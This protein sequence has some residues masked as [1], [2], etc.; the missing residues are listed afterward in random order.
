[1][2]WLKALARADD[3]EG[4]GTGERGRA[5]P[6]LRAA[7]GLACAVVACAG[8]A[9]VAAVAA[10]TDAAFVAATSTSGT[11][12]A[13]ALTATTVQVTRDCTTVPPVVVG[14]ATSVSDRSSPMTLTLPPHQV[15][16]LL[17]VVATSSTASA[18]TLP[19]GWTTH[20]A[21]A[22]V[23]LVGV[24]HTVASRVATGADTTVTVSLAGALTQGGAVAVAVRGATASPT[25]ASTAVL[26]L[27]AVTAPHVPAPAGS[28]VLTAM[29]ADS[30]TA[31]TAPSGTTAVGSSRAGL[32]ATVV[33][34]SVT[35][36]G[37]DATGRSSPTLVSVAVGTTVVLAPATPTPA[38]DA[39]TWTAVSDAAGYE[40]RVDGG[41]AVPVT[42]AWQVEDDRG[43]AALYE[44]RAVRGAWRGPWAGA[45]AAACP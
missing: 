38:R 11:L 19:T 33:A 24:S 23:G 6:R 25:A 4:V 43:T 41:Q 7:A 16:D 42:S 3:M 5:R 45:S 27:G 34:R 35:T 36:T 22:S 37:S 12:A 40:G 30:L 10:P 15:G 1:M 8:L 9:A 14:A 44:V 29:S 32:D 20:P 2:P 39:V 13:T 17:V 21:S 18:P 31:V 26:S 28:L